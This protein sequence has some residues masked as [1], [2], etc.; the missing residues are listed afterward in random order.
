MNTERSGPGFR[1]GTGGTNDDAWRSDLAILRL[2]RAA[3][4]AETALSGGFAATPDREDRAQEKVARDPAGAPAGND[5]FPGLS[6]VP[7]HRC[8]RFGRGAAGDSPDR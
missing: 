8:R 5:E 1:Q 3:A 4:G 2:F 6:G 7:L